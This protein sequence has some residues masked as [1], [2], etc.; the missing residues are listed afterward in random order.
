MTEF[1]K[2]AKALNA[3]A[4]A[5]AIKQLGKDQY[6]S[7]PDAAKAIEDDFKAGCGW[8]VKWS[9]EQVKISS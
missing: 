6:A 2:M 8:I 3:A 9:I 7:N 5:H 1:K 4:K